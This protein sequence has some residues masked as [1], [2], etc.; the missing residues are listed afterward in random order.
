[1]REGQVGS[2][3]DLSGTVSGAL[4][5]NALFVWDQVNPGTTGGRGCRHIG[6]TCLRWKTIKRKYQEIEEG[7]QKGGGREN[8]KEHAEVCRHVL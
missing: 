2:I 7:R 1:M 6:S 3:Q 5:K 8:T 4:G